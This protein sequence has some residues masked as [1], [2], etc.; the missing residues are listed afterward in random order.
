MEQRVFL[1]MLLL[2]TPLIT[3]TEGLVEMTPSRPEPRWEREQEKIVHQFRR[4]IT[5]GT[6][7]L[8]V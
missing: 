1:Y 3:F 4:A 6:T 2:W 8:L 7:H 5:S